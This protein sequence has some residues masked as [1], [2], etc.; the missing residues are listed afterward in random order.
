LKG[1]FYAFL[2]F[3]TN[4]ALDRYIVVSQSIFNELIKYRIDPSKIY[5][6]Y[7]A[8]DAN[9]DQILN[10][11]QTLIERLSLPSDSILIVTA[12]RFVWAKG[13]DDLV[14][15]FKLIAKQNSNV[16]CLI[17]GDGELYLKLKT[18]IETN[19]L[20]G[21]V[22]LLGQISRDEVLSLVK[23]CDIFVMSS[24]SEGTPMVLL[25]A[26]SLKKPIL[27]TNVGGIP[28][29]LKNEEECLLVPPGNLNAFAN[30]LKRILS[31]KQLSERLARA[32]YL[33][34]TQ[35]FSIGNQ[36]RDTVA[37]YNQAWL[38]HRSV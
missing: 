17:A 38:N 2:E 11:K 21:R 33:R 10:L 36:V 27:S 20:N 26:A 5:L 24:R 6:I 12:G 4:F 7:N 31:D 9:G 16:Y 18:K 19:G 1:I 8:I 3:G 35:D 15:A 23:A 13:Y 34:V 14:D 37:V 30:S 28:E 29:L 25:E 32:A 22:I